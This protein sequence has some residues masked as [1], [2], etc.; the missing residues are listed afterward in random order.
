VPGGARSNLLT[1]AA[2]GALV[3]GL[4]LGIA[5]HRIEG[6]VLPALARVLQPLG[7]LWLNAFQMTVIPL[8]VAQIL[9]AFAGPR[10][11]AAVGQIGLRAAVLFT[12]AL[13]ASGF[14]AAALARVPLSLY[15]VSPELVA[16]IRQ[17]VVVP[18]L[19]G[20]S[21]G[22]S[23]L[24]WVT[25]LVPSNLFAAAAA[26]QILPL[27]VA[28][29]VFGLALSRLPDPA[30]QQLGQFF[31][32]TT[33]AMLVVIRWILWGAPVAVFALVLGVT[34]RS[35]GQVIGVLGAYLLAASAVLVILT[36]A[37]YPLAVGLGRTSWR[38]F[39]RAAAPAQM[40]GLAT[41]SSLA[42]LPA[43]VESGRRFLRYSDTTAGF[44]VPLCTTAFKPSTPGS[45]VVKA[46]FI[47]QVFGVTLSLGQ[48]VAF[49]AAMVL[50][51]FS[52][53]GVPRGGM[54]S[55]GLPAY[56]A[57]GLPIEGYFLLEAVDDLIDLPQTLNNVTGHVGM[58]AVLSRK[59]RTPEALE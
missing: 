4:G 21:G 38:D 22:A 30:R 44:T 56:L 12:V 5:G 55:R 59:D 7:A 49:V 42:A 34:L 50:I 43:H 47:G 54:P 31:Q 15:S 24:D 33:D 40:I 20:P 19:A 16:S 10:A 27:F 53:V 14:A 46:L 39:V 13:F 18:S 26:G 45:A 9:A 23:G 8:V 6:T 35:G 41:R 11:A 29:I 51:S 17:S 36:L 2:F 57:V 25:G 3:L 28:A 1:I 48:L 52:I 32:A 58:A 37:I